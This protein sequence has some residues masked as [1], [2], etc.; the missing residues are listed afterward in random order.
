MIRHHKQEE[1]LDALGNPI[2]REILRLLTPGPQPVGHIAR[3]LPV[4]RPAVSKH[5]R[6]LEKAML[7]THQGQGNKNLFRLNPSGF[8]AAKDWLESFWDSA[9]ARFA[10]LATT[11]TAPKKKP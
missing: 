2:R 11:T 8:E 4:S 5:L 1:I 10:D 7:V 3:A 6:I 9:L